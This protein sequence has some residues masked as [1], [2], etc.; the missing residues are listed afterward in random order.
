[1]ALWNPTKCFELQKTGR[2]GKELRLEEREEVGGRRPLS[3]GV[4]DSAGAR[5]GLADGNI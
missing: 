3:T 1:M 2:N 5:L 4:E